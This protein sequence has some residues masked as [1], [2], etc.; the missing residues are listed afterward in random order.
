MQLFII[1]CQLLII[2]KKEMLYFAQVKKNMV[3]G[4]LELELLAYQEPDSVIWQINTNSI[5]LS[6]D[7]D[8]FMEG[9][10][11]LVECTENRI[12]TDIENAKDWII[13]LIK[14]YLTNSLITSEVVAK[15]QEKIEK[16]RQ[17]IAQESQDLTRRHL[18]LET[19]REELQELEK[20]LKRE[21][22]K[23][24]ELEQNL[25]TEKQQIADGNS[26]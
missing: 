11:L 20:S 10:L 24:Q 16:W 26:D 14:Q 7:S 4:N 17:E 15:E 18:E 23:L 6:L 25:Q 13:N 5:Y 19:R 22:Q 8:E 12:I 21:Q 9:V 3:S 2:Y 1:N